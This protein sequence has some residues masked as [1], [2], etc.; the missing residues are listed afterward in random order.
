MAAA[1]C[2]EC[3]RRPKVA[4]RHRCLTCALR[5]EPIGDQVAAA[6]RR[7][8][9]VPEELRVKRTKAVQADAPAGTA[10]CAGCQSYRDLEDFGKSATTCRAC[11]SAKTHATMVAKVYGLA[12]GDYEKLLEQQGKRCAICRA[13]PR[14]KRLAVDH[15]HKTGAVRGLL[16]SRCNHDLM[17]S[18]WDSMAIAAALWHY[19]NTPPATGQWL[20]PE[21]QLPLAVSQAPEGPSKAS[22]PSRALLVTNA[23]NEPARP[24][25]APTA[26]DSMAAAGPEC[27]TPHFLPA[28]A[29]TVPGKRGVWK[30]WVSADPDADPPF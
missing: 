20:P 2:K 23:G 5:H 3:H 12:P 1:P 10:W 17:G 13:K 24:R 26:I 4:G 9:L 11:T 27:K 25:R 29:E 22:D 8:G 14:S 19:L 15:D 21:D 6:L 28:G 30:V 7:R 16:C 18:A